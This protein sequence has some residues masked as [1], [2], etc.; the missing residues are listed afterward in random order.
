[1][2]EAVIFDMDGLLVDSEPYWQKT[3]RILMKEIGLDITEDMQKETF[4]LS[5][6]EMILHW[7]N[8]QAWPN[9]DFIKLGEIY[10][11]MMLHFFKT[12]AELLPGAEYI[13]RFFKDK[14]MKSGLASSSSMTLINAFIDKFDLS[15]YIQQAHSA[16]S[17]NFS[18]PHPAVYIETAKK[19]GVLPINCLAFEDSINGV[20]S[21]KAARMK[22]VAVP[23]TKHYSIPGYEIANLKIKS[24]KEFGEEEFKLIRNY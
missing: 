6:R 17:E 1:M 22:V 3:E 11:E 12:Q 14:E 10:E 5:T 8:Y 4:G 2:V 19:L 15:E 23:D 13:L 21:A 18:K 24:L 9:P 20:V 7:Y 16:E